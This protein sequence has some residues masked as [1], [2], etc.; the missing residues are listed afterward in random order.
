MSKSDR[1]LCVFL[2]DTTLVFCVV[3]SS[4]PK[5]AGRP[6]AGM[7]LL[8][9][10]FLSVVYGNNR[11]RRSFLRDEYPPTHNTT[12]RFPKRHLGGPLTFMHT[13]CK[14]RKTAFPL[15]SG[16]VCCFFAAHLLCACQV[17]RVCYSTC[18]IHVEENE[19]VV[20][21]ALEQ[22]PA[23]PPPPPNSSSGHPAGAAVT[24]SAA[25][26]SNKGNQEKLEVS[27]P[28][29]VVSTTVSSST[30]DT[31]SVGIDAGKVTSG[32]R[33][34]LS[35][36][37]SRWPRR[38]L[39]VRGL[40]ENQAAC[41][42]RTDPSEDETNGFFVAVFEREGGETKKKRNR[43]KNKNKN[44]K[45]NKKKRKREEAEG[46]GEGLEGLWDVATQ[47][48]EVS[49]VAADSNELDLGLTVR[50]ETN[51]GEETTKA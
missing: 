2:P 41:M 37:L 4:Q 13:S 29:R 25:P 51:G 31:A 32:G 40:D 14:R 35:R 16:V 36:C 50:V 18:S 43:N 47:N 12:D 27:A 45:K 9:G 17:R 24:P 11:T 48:V 20:A 34:K 6:P 8:H 26:S 1:C 28:A 46:L 42:V 21:K 38:G 33:F 44:R 39:A 3:F 10:M 15:S 19:A 22:Q 23:P 5:H 7:A 49:G 30:Q